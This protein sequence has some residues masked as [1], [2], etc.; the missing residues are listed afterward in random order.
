MTLD[1]RLRP[2]AE[3]DLAEAAVWYQEQQPGLGQRFL[4]A[5]AATI[6]RIS[7]A[8]LAFPLVYGSTRRA[9]LRRF[10][11]GVFFQVEGERIVVIGVLHGS[12]HPH[13]WRQR[14]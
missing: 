4:D 11:F 6:S 10:P 5:A 14:L 1:V 7:T 8:S 2:E 3:D 13:A 12:R 9:L